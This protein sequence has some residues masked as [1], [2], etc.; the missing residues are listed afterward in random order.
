MHRIVA[1][2]LKRYPL[3]LFVLLEV[4]AVSMV[5][6]GNNYHKSAF[7]VGV[8]DFSGWTYARWS[9][10]TGYFYLRKQN[11]LL[12][13]ENARLKN[14]LKSSFRA[15]DRKEF[16]WNDTLYQQQFH[17]VSSRVVNS[18]VNRKKNFLVID[19]GRRQGIEND[20]GVIAPDG[21]VGMVKQVS[22]NYALVIP[23][24]NID[25]NIAARLKRSEQ[26]G[27]VHW[28]GT[29]F[30]HA[31]MKGIPGH[32]PLQKGDTVITSG[33]SIFFPE[34]IRVGYVTDFTKNRSDNFYTIKLRLAVDFNSIHFVYVIR[35]LLAK[36]QLQL[37]QEVEDEQ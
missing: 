29:D 28:D 30:S 9:N 11:Q 15:S 17:Y 31:V 24:I 32:T 34:G 10:L 23:V 33:Q 8:T 37:L 6:T 27:L 14:N 5:V 1:F 2:L 25:A 35:D 18:S 36:E 21:I 20:M 7:H 13:E 22:A 4:V 3:F 26:K 16:V 19:K 12:A